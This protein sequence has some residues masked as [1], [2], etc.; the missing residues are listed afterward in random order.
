MININARVY[1]ANLG[2]YNEGELVGQWLSL[3]ATDEEKEALFVAIGLG[4][5]VNGEYVHGLTVDGV[6]YEECA[7]H[8]Y[9]SDID[10]LEFDEYLPIDAASE[11]VDAIERLCEYELDTLRAAIE[12]FGEHPKQV[13][14]NI[15]EFRLYDASN[16]EE[17][18]YLLADEGYIEIP[19]NL[20]NYFDFEAFGRDCA[21]EMSGGFTSWG[22]VEWMR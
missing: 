2:K 15:D 13:A 10:G 1:V 21:I 22:F 17:L 5:M 3:P 14:E 8:D 6:C 12:C 4:Q 7:I 19:S 9:E 20:T 16:E 18:G 11:M